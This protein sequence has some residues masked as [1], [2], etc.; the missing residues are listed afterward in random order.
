MTLRAI[1]SEATSLLSIFNHSGLMILR[2]QHRLSPER[3]CEIVEWFGRPFYRG[4]TPN[5]IDRLFMVSDL[6]LQLL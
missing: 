4:A 2:D 1:K 6:P 5:S 3:Q